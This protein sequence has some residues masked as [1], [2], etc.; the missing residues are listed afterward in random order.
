[1]RTLFNLIKRSIGVIMFAAIPGMAT[2]AATGIGPLLGA[3]NGVATVFSSIII[4]FGVQLAWDAQISDEDVE[5]GFRA[6]VAKQA[7]ENKDIA[8][9]VETSA[10]D[11]S[12]L[13]E[14]GDLTDLFDDEEAET[15]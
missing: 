13:D 15:L 10:K 12:E 1:M 6:A 3:L 14:F 7:S 8:A 9:A 2:G 4:F 5:K 11:I